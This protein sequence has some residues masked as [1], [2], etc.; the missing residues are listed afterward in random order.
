[1][2]AHEMGHFKRKHILKNLIVS[3]THMGLI[4]FLLSFFITLPDLFHAFYMHDVSVYGGLIFFGILY[5]PI[6]IIFSILMQMSSP[7]VS[8]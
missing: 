7:Y 8:G 4:F 1:M 3:I 5:S 2:T 6:E